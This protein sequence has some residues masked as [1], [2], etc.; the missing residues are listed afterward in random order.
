MLKYL[1][2]C[3]KSIKTIASS[4]F[5]KRK[6]HQTI[7]MQPDFPI[8]IYRHRR[9]NLKKCSLRG[10]ESNP[11]FNFFTYPQDELPDLDHYILLDIT[12]SPLTQ[13]DAHKGLLIIDGTWRYAATMQKQIAPK[14]R[15]VIKRSIPSSI[16]TA[17]PRRQDDCPNPKT[18][19]ASVEALF[20]ACAILGWPTE[21][22]LDNYH[23]KDRFFELNNSFFSE[24][25]LSTIDFK[26]N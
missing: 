8:L 22:L 18:G 15:N 4:G 26:R 10:L 2:T 1:S 12:A 20:V 5:A 17:Y 3:N 14:T 16:I 23:W 7:G 13:V 19:L 21:T 25:E 11:L 9:E 24:L 6:I